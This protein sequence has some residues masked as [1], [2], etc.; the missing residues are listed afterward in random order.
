MCPHY[1]SDLISGQ[2]FGINY[3]AVLSRLKTRF[4]WFPHISPFGLAD[5]YF[6]HNKVSYHL[7]VEAIRDNNKP[8]HSV[9]VYTYKVATLITNLI[10]LIS[11]SKLLNV[12]EGKTGLYLSLSTSLNLAEFALQYLKLLLFSLVA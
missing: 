11:D 12:C 2:L 5:C 3:V 6:P 1:R 4:L 8:V 9:G 7:G 10:F